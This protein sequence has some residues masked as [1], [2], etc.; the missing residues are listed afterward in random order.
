MVRHL[1]EIGGRQG[2]LHQPRPQGC[3]ADLGLA[4]T[5]N[6]THRFGRQMQG[7]ALALQKVQH[8]CDGFVAP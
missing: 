4:N 7:G 2:G 3:F 6:A 1:D 8:L 5:G